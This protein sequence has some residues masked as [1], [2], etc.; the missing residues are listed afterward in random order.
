MSA[1]PT[2]LGSDDRHTCQQCSALRSGVCRAAKP[3]GSVS[4]VVGYR[5]AAPDMLHRCRSFK[6]VVADNSALGNLNP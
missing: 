1:L 6:A 4:A 2:S 5:P 3:G